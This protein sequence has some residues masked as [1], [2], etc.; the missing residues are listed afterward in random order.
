MNSKNKITLVIVLLIAVIIAAFFTYG[1]QAAA[2]TATYSLNSTT[3]TGATGDAS[4]TASS[5]QGQSVM[6]ASLAVISPNGG[7][8][9]HSGQVYA[10]TWKAVG[11]EKVYISLV[12]G[13]KEFGTMG[14]FDATLQSYSWTVP[15]E[16][17]WVA[18][19]LDPKNFKIFIT[20]TTDPNI[21]DESDGAFTISSA[22]SS[23]SSNSSQ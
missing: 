4:S 21:R 10:I 12:N 18:S 15:D 7:E 16:S 22:V 3:T 11:V 20:S 23:S 5:S 9:L 2:P 1:R 13:G 19:G 6:P 14:P 17:G 8:T